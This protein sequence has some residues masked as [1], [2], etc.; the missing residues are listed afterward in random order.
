MCFKWLCRECK[1]DKYDYCKEYF[2]TGKDWCGVIVD[3]VESPW[4]EKHKRCVTCMTIRGAIHRLN[5]M[6]E[7]EPWW[8]TH[9]K[10]GEPEK[11]AWELEAELEAKKEAEKE[12]IYDSEGEDSD[13]YTK[14]ERK[15][16]RVKAQEAVAKRWEALKQEQ[17]EKDNVAVEVFTPETDSESK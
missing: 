14:A 6:V 12:G 16:I 11:P 15:E 13:G 9:G 3:I 8:V 4:D 2:D 7:W 1:Q 17:V 5:A 10:A